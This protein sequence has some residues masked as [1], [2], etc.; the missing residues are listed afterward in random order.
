MLLTAEPTSHTS[1]VATFLNLEPVLR[2]PAAQAWP[3]NK[4]KQARRS[5]PVRTLYGMYVEVKIYAAGESVLYN[6]ST[7]V[8][9]KQCQDGWLWLSRPGEG[10]RF[11]VW[12][13]SV[14]EC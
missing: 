5:F 11:R 12:P 13:Y 6:G 9:E 14:Q 8:V 2:Y 1:P 10:E 4:A 3:T 7:A